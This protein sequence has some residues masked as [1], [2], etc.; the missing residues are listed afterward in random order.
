MI[1]MWT[2]ILKRCNITSKTLQ[3]VTTDLSTVVT[4]YDSLVLY[5]KEFRNKFVQVE[6]S[7]KQITEETQYSNELSRR[8]TKKKFF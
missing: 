7:A 6:Q 1:M 3:T 5:I 8:K 4:L 2:P